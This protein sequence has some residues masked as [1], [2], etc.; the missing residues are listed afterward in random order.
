MKKVLLV[1]TLVLGTLVSNGQKTII[2]EK[3]GTATFK[4]KVQGVVTIT[5]STLNIKSSYKGNVSE[6]TLKIV[7]RDENTAASIYNCIGQIGTSDKHQ[8]SFVTSMDMGIWTMVNSFTN[9]K[10]EQYMVLSK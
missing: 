5:D 4:V 9:E 6:Y 1:L 2:F 10:L 3:L 7:S 8:F